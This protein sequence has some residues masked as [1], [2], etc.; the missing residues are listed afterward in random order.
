MLFK[1][2]SRWITATMLVVT[3]AVPATAAAELLDRV[4]AVVNDDVVLLSEFREEL[5]AARA[6]LAQRD[7]QAPPEDQLRRQVLD[8]LV[9]QRLQLDAAE[10]A[11]V[12]V[13]EATLD[14]AVRQVA[15]QNDL[16]LPG[17]R[18]A[19]QREGMTMAGFRER[20]RR[21]ITLQRLHR[22]AMD[23]R[24]N[25]T[26]QEID[27]FQSQ[28]AE[29]EVEYRLRHLLVALPEA[30]SPEAIESAREKAEGLRR[31]LTGG[32]ANFA[33]LAATHSDGRNAL[34]G[35]D[36]GWR[37]AGE[38]PAVV[39]G[40][41]SDLQPGDVSDVLRTPSGFH[42]FKVEDR[43]DAER[44]VV[45]Q[46]RARHIL[47]RTNEVVSD[48]DARRR[49]SALRQRVL[50]GESF[51]ELARANSDDKA[52]ATEGGSLGWVTPGSMAPEFERVMQRLD[53]GAI[54]QPFRS[55]FGWHIVQVHERREQDTTETYRRNQAA[56]QLRQRK[57]EEE[58]ELWLRQLREEA[59]VDYRLEATGSS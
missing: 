28:I 9:M 14:A 8:R 4:V 18:D 15:R 47:I 44:H 16:D 58:L 31:E 40:K 38:L 7:I 52:S 24:I 41:L 48:Q 17:F 32:D 39:A 36:L 49:L 42:L 57:E 55:R 6:Q 23:Q 56:Q 12:R 50:S 29:R 35:G 25:I 22:S 37:R 10:R 11:G 27:Q 34:E 26:P 21:E 43:R 3:L 54:S 30:A 33:T 20:L 2:L 51:A 1:T 59:Y 45:T 13:D 5:T 19:L 53:P 46:T